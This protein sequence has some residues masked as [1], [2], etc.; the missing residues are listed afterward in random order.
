MRDGHPPEPD[1]GR[2]MD[3][4]LRRAPV[5]IVAVAPDGTVRDVNDRAETLLGTARGDLGGETIEVAFPA[6]ATGDLEAAFATT[7]PAARSFEE[8]YPT[9]ERWLAVDIVPGEP[10]T[11]VYVRDCTTRHEHERAVSR[12][13]QRLA[14]IESIDETVARVL[15]GIVD[16]SGREELAR[17]VCDGLG[18]V[19]RYGLC[20]IGSH[21]PGTDRLELLAARGDAREARDSITEA[22]DATDRLPEERAVEAGE[23]RV[24]RSVAEDESVPRPVRV[25]AFG[26][27]LQSVAAVPI[28][29]RETV[30]GVLGIYSTD[31][32]G[33]EEQEVA[34]L[35]TLGAVAGFALHATRQADRLDADR[36]LEL[37]LDIDGP[38]LPLVAA[39]RAGDCSLTVVGVTPRDDG[40]AV[41]YLRGTA[42]REAVTGALADHPGVAR[43][44]VVRDEDDGYLVEAELDGR[45]PIR[46]LAARPVT[47][48]RVE[49]TADGQRAVVHAAPDQEVRALVAA[50]ADAASE[51]SLAAKRERTTDPG[52]RTTV[53]TDLDERLTDRQRT[54]LR[55]A[56]VADYFASPRGSTAEEVATALDVTGPTVLYHLRAAQRKLLGAYFDI[57][58]SMED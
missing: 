27:G 2:P 13:E 38:E 16:T 44:R 32:H 48:E 30:Y 46:A 40:A 8:Y 53:R 14:R 6:S 51:V 4:R 52:E 35:E 43:T 39:A 57:D 54:V 23:T 3:E 55:T 47:V 11:L 10:E 50:V 56:Y 31:E 18:T 12:L 41:C 22:L 45:S 25:A 19:E 9:V 33:F 17:T 58:P 29:Y 37:I 26:R 34:S 20:W 15:R 24:V 21:P 49:V 1:G 28:A 36:V 7:P 5:G 42:G